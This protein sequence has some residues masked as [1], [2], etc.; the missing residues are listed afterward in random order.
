MQPGQPAALAQ[1][2]SLWALV[3]V[4]VF[5]LQLPEPELALLRRPHQAVPAA[6]RSP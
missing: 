1:R 6:A 5:L 4:L 2:L 3:S